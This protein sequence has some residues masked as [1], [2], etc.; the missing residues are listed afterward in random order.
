LYPAQ[1]TYRY[2]LK[3][4]VETLERLCPTCQAPLRVINQDTP[5]AFI[6]CQ[7]FPQC[8]Y[9]ESVG[10]QG[11]L[12]PQCHKHHIVKRFSKV[13]GNTFYGCLG[14]PQ[15]KNT[16]PFPP[17]EKTCL[18]GATIMLQLED[19]TLKCS[20]CAKVLPAETA[21]PLSATDYGCKE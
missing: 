1:C 8:K 19:H 14:Y 4:K 20:E 7:G 11:I 9:T 3:T 21:A 12:C 2:S 15:C 6:G 10:P 13:R 17:L 18:C 5:K 16:Y